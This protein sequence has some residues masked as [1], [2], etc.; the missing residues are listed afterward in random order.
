VHRLR[1][2]YHSTTTLT[3]PGHTTQHACPGINYLAQ[4]AT[5]AKFPVL[6]ACNMDMTLEPLLKDKIKKW[7]T[8]NLKGVNVA[9]LGYANTQQS[10]QMSTVTKNIKFHDYVRTSWHSSAYIPSRLGIATC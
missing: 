9:I 5:N 7:A 6:G 4:F 1:E 3:V 8:F 10:A 2:H